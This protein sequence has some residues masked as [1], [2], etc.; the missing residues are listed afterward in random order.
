MLEHRML[1]G[2]KHDGPEDR[3]MEQLACAQLVKAQ[4]S[5]EQMLR[6]ALTREAFYATPRPS[7]S[8]IA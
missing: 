2:I 5:D 8:S 6:C 1:H 3:Q 7:A 4:S